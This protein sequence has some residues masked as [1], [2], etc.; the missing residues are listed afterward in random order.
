MA[1]I[2]I[3]S[4]SPY[5]DDFDATK[6]YVQVLFR[7]G[8]PVQARELTTLQSF[9]QEQTTRLGDAIFADGGIVKSAELTVTEDVHQMVLSGSGNSVYTSAGALNTATLTTIENLVGTVISDQNDTI[10]AR[11]IASPNGVNTTSQIG[12][13]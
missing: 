11:V 1:E 8:Y 13:I 9:L 10:Q 3:R 7:P 12:N 6:D 5:Y 2:T 4:Q